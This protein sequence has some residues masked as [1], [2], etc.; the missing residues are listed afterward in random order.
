MPRPS[1]TALFI[2]FRVSNSVYFVVVVVVVVVTVYVFSVCV[3]NFSVRPEE[4]FVV[5]GTASSMSLNP[6]SCAGG[7]LVVYRVVDL[8]DG[9][10]KLEFVHKVGDLPR[11]QI[12]QGRSGSGVGRGREAKEGG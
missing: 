12:Q 2:R 8:M 4:T 5:I 3:C 10:Q 11:A 9:G 7:F 6:R 1:D